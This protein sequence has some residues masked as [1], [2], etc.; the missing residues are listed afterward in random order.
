M[1]IAMLRI[2]GLIGVA[3]F[4]G[5]FIATWMLPGYVEHAGSG[6]IRSQL[7]KL[8]HEKIDSLDQQVGGGALGQLAEG[9]IAR[10]EVQIDNAKEQLHAAL[11]E[12]IAA[13]VAEMNDLSCEC[14]TKYAQAIREGMNPYVTSLE[15]LNEKLQDFLKTKYMELVNRV[16][17]DFRIFTACNLA[18]FMLLLS[19]SFL[20]PQAV[21]LLFFPAAL[22]TAATVICSYFYLFEQNWFFTLLYNDFVGISYLGYVVGVFLFL[23]DIALNRGRVTARILNGIFQGVGSGFSVVPC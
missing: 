9:V 22:L 17:A 23:C 13:V 4:G 12:R 5:A 21:V 18:V 10:N 8:A 11:P 19:V 3:L 14:R 7:E 6:F 1:K 20:K 16:V 15:A 2:V